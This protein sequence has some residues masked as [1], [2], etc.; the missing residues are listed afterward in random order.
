MQ[1]WRLGQ[2][3]I[4]R[5]LEFEMPFIA[6]AT[7]YPES[8]PALINRHRHWLEPNLLDPTTGLLTLA[9]HSLVIKTPQHTILVDT[10]SGNDKERPHK[11]G[12]HRK[13][14]PYL[15]NLQAAGFSPDDIDF[16]LCTHLHADHVGWNTRL[17]DGTWIPTFPR[18]RYLLARQEWEH[19]RSSELRAR[20]TTDPYYED[21]ILPVLNCG[22]VAFVTMDHIID[23]WVRLEATPGHTPGHV[24]VIVQSEGAAAVL[25]GDLLHT[26]MQC[27]EPQ[28][29]SCFCVDAVMSR[30]TRQQFL[31]R[32]ADTDT[33][34][35]PAH[36]PTPTAGRVRT[37]GDAFLFDFDRQY[38]VELV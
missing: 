38:Q 9:F 6:P 21:S 11:T 4:A 25:S 29:N 24:N 16:V 31:R 26:A 20:Y 7:L 18:A 36:F 27:A 32:Y 3:T 5:V 33:L 35:F 14:W 13:R 17:V 2:I 1:K 23:D 22:Q 19:W 37:R 10:C 30:S 34:V 15:E 28:L 8:T 12:Y